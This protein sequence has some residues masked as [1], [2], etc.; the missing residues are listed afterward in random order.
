VSESL[1]DKVENAIYDSWSEGDE[2][3]DVTLAAY[4][5]L[6]IPEIAEALEAYRILCAAPGDGT[7]S[8]VRSALH[9]WNQAHKSA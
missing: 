2:C 9:D 7:V 5:V 4:R 8:E 1:D 6:K 3:F